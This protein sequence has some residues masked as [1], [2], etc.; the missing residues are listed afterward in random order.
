MLKNTSWRAH[1]EYETADYKTISIWSRLILISRDL[2]WV[3]LPG[4]IL[5]EKNSSS[6][7]S[8]SGHFW[9]S[10]G[11]AM[12]ETL[13]LALCIFVVTGFATM[14]LLG[15]YPK[16]VRGCCRGF[17][18]QCSFAINCCA[19]THHKSRIC[20]RFSVLALSGMVSWSLLSLFLDYGNPWEVLAVYTASVR[21]TARPLP[22][23]F[24]GAVV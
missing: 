7:E 21:S 16:H 12:G 1:F 20:R 23:A 14:L 9:R 17:K 4:A 2:I 6:T 15:Y 5:L 22:S 10:T 24:A 3:I 8:V 11:V 18:R 13:G 19:C